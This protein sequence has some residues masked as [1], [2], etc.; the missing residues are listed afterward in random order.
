[1]P[2][3]PANKQQ[4]SLLILIAFVMGGIGGTFLSPA[5]VRLNGPGIFLPDG[6]RR[7]GTL[8]ETAFSDEES[9][10]ISVV[11]KANAA[12]V[13]VTILKD[14]AALRGQTNVQDF[15][16]FFEFG[17]PFRMIPPQEMPNP[18]NGQESLREIGGGSGFIIGADGLIVTNKHVVSDDAATYKVKLSSGKE[19]DAKVIAKDPLMD[20]ALIKIEATGLPT[21][22]LGDSE[23]LRLG[24]SVIAIGNALA[25]FGNTVTRGVVSGV[26][27]RVEA[28]DGMGMTEVIEEAIQTDAAINRGNSGG[29]LLNLAGEVIG[30][31]TAVSSEGQ[32]LGFAI[33]INNVK[34]TIESVQKTG[35]ISRPWL[36]V[37]YVLVTPR[38]AE[39]NKLSVTYGAL[40]LRGRTDS[41]LAV[42]PGSPADKA[43]LAENDIILS[44]DGKKIEDDNS[45][46]REIGKHQVGDEVMLKVLQKGKEKDIKVKLEEFPIK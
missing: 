7:A 35:R 20:V 22:A 9:A 15:E 37:R 26:G 42:I 18:N 28:G 23:K 46:A 14:I 16:D 45:L 17:F 44:I 41:D 10:T 13:N 40:I 39:E 6:T 24:Q 43:G 30:I 11:E 12:V 32:L 1:M 5:L 29:P 36:G 27:R 19:Y 8:Q 31:N 4:V 25:E 38:I 21:L 3:L 33:P 2:M 34:R